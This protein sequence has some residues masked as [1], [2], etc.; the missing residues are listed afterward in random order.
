[1][2]GQTS[3]IMDWLP[4]VKLHNIWSVFKLPVTFTTVWLADGLAIGS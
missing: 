3:D 1:M 4:L 2:S